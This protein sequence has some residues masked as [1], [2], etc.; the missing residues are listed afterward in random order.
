MSPFHPRHSPQS[1][2]IRPPHP[3]ASILNPHNNYHTPELAA[4]TP[5]PSVAATTKF[6]PSFWRFNTTVLVVHF[7][8]LLSILI[9]LCP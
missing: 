3:A 4:A 8:E 5:N 6:E 1:I 9:C 7:F 2:K